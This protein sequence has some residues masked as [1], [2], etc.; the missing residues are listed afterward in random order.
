MLTLK[1]DKTSFTGAHF[2][3]I[4]G[5]SVRVHVLLAHCVELYLENV[6]RILK[7]VVLETRY[8]TLL[9]SH[10]DGNGVYR[11]YA[12]T[13]SHTHDVNRSYA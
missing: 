11:H 5:K 2:S 4:V 13:H 3:I 10:G 12:V 9:K 8:I 7:W 6:F 1:F